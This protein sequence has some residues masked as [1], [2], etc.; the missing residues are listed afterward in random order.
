MAKRLCVLVALLVLLVGTA[1]GQ[2]AQSV[3]RAAATAMGDPSD[4]R[5]IQYSGTGWVGALGQSYSPNED[6]PRFEVTSYTRTIDYT[7][8]SSREE[9]TR[10]QGDYPHRGGGGTPIQ[11]EQRRISMTRG[12]YAWRVQGNN[13]NPLAPGAA[14]VQQLDIWL[15]PHGFLKAAMEGNPTAVS[16]TLEG[17]KKTIVSFTALG[18]YRVNGTINEENLVERVQTWVPNPALGDMVYEHRYTEYK[19]FGGARFPTVLH[20]HQGD[21]R[22]NAGHNTMEIRVSNARVNVSA[23]ALTVPD[24]VRQ[25]TVPAVRVEIEELA[26]GI[27]LFG[28]GSHNSVVVEFRDFVAVVEAPRNEERSLAA[29][30]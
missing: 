19:D 8:G 14:A 5:S 26:N 1:T 30:G 20:S 7:A 28:G 4:V 12:K 21:P 13:A 6:W 2:D 17:R 22:L 15:S 11:G 24:A 16:L 29:R 10:R 23:P 25:A 3:L 18:K 9:Y 27:W